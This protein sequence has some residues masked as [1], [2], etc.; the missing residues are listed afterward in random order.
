MDF[1]TVFFIFSLLA[2]VVLVYLLTMLWFSNARTPQLKSFIGFG[3]AVGLWTFFSA[4]ATVAAP[5]YFTLLY[6]LHTVTG[7]I[8]PYVFVWYALTFSGSRLTRL[9]A[10]RV[11]LFLLPALDAIAFATN[12]LHRLMFLTYD[13]P[14]LP[15]GPLFWVH[16][17]FGYA[18]FLVSLVTLFRHA[19]RNA[20]N[21]LLIPAA[22]S[23][24]IPFVVNVLLALNLLGTRHDFTSISFFVTFTLFFLVTYRSAPF[25]FKSVALTNI[26]TSLSDMILIANARGVI[27]DANAAFH[28]TFPRFPI[29]L[30][31]TT[32]AEFADWLSVRVSA[33][34]SE[35]LLT[36][37][38]DI[39]R[40]YES[41]EFSLRLADCAELPSDAPGGDALL[42]FTLRRDLIQSRKRPSGFLVTMSDVS[43]YRGMILEMNKQK[44]LA[45]QASKTKSTFLANMS[46]EIRTPINAITGM[47]AIARSTEDVT[48]IHDCLDKV[49][50]ASRQL[51]GVINDI[52]DMS[53]IEANRMELAPEAFDLPA[54][55]TNLG[56]IME[57]SAEAKQQMLEVTL[58]PN[59]PRVAVGDELRLSQIFLNLLSNAVKFTP[60]HGSIRLSVVCVEV[61]GEEIE[62]E[63]TVADSGIGIS[64]EQ[65]KRLFSSF[66]Q[67]DK[68][69]SKRFGGTGLGLAISR[70]LA[71]LMK[72]DIT[73]ESVFGEGSCFTVRFCLQ[74]GGEELVVQ[75]AETL[76]YD[77]SGRKALLAEDLAI[78]R[79]I[80]LALLE[81]SG[82]QVDCAENGQEAL[83][84]YLAAPERYDI[85]FMD[86]HMPVV[87]GYTATRSIRASGAA[88]AA[89]VPI[90]AMTANAFAED[91]T[92]CHVA[93]MNDHIAKPIELPLLLRKMAKL[94]T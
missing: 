57:V 58:A 80:V 27:V 94:M 44:E 22:F 43:A 4:I 49:D 71:Q 84:A 91:V 11:L 68:G 87:D 24:L 16:A 19:F 9:K 54:L 42:T 1:N 14:D 90:L 47:A 65:K 83:E 92:N 77:F 63:A 89:T 79:E 12:P 62:L 81:E 41:G 23:T 13:Y 50:A 60:D 52:L 69:T 67:A 21:T 6:T 28:S 30:G 2:C 34:Q 78:N 76:R 48:R 45:E 88:T 25:S 56:D 46:H 72:G 15:T 75:S 64:E 5:E 3:G 82:I 33:N 59:L 26:F 38:P 36:D 40:L 7:C 70:H 32:A 51:L 74:I 35:T 17:I 66:E 55:F 61:R 37:L 18:A 73:L 8:F 39:K 93:G 20:R 53:K 85:I 86:I 31:K 10:V 29:T